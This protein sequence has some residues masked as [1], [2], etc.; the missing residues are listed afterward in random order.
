MTDDI[1]TCH[2]PRDIDP[3]DL[4]TE[5]DEDTDRRLGAITQ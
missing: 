3:E 4:R 1:A 5:D 2:V